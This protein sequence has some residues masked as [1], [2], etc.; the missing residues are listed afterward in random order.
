[1]LTNQGPRVLEFNVRFGD[2]ECQAILMR[3][4]SDLLEVLDAVVDERLDTVAL[5]WDP[6]PAVTVVMASEGYPGHYERDRVINN[7]EEAERMPDVKVFHAGTTLRTD[8]TLGRDGRIVTDGGRVLDVTALGPNLAAA[9]ARAYEA[10]RA[11]RFTG[12]QYRRDIADRA[13]RAASE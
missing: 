9:Q 1:M 12:A 6:R 8:P 10:V 3:L 5:R 7:L 4:E 13:I 11:I 2:P